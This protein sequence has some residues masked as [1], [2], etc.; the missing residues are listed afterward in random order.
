MYATRPGL[1]IGFHGC[2]IS[3]RDNVVNHRTSLK[4]S[5]NQYDWLGSGIYFW[6]NNQQRALQFAEELMKTPRGKKIK[7]PA[8]LGA[9]IDIGFCL[10]LLDTEYLNLLSE[11]YT[12]LLESCK[13][14]GLEIPVNKDTTGSADLLL[15]HLDC[16]VIE[17]LHLQRKKNKFKEF[18]AV[19]SVF[20]EGKALYEK[21]GFHSKNHIQICIRNPNCIKGFFIPLE[22]NP[23]YNTP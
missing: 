13:L 4:N 5:T 14:L 15:R 3:L 8:V 20:V 9:V 21:S 17:N 10:D 1:I 12:T 7:T 18:D 19:R 22:S 2:D 6:E 11:S 16:A 23:D